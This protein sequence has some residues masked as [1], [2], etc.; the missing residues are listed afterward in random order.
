[1]VI[2]YPKGYSPRAGFTKIAVSFPSD[3]F[4]EIIKQAKKEDLSFNELVVE[5]C[6]VGKFDLDESDAM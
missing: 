6:K 4:K 3:F 2:K 1:V 5:Y